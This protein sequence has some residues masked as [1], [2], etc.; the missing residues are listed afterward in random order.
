MLYTCTEEDNKG[1][2]GCQYLCGTDPGVLNLNAIFGAKLSKNL[3]QYFPFEIDSIGAKRYICKDINDVDQIQVL[4]YTNKVPKDFVY[5]EICYK[6]TPVKNYK[7]DL[8]PS[9]NSFNRIIL[10][11]NKFSG[12]ISYITLTDTEYDTFIKNLT[13][14]GQII[15]SDYDINKDYNSYIKLLIGNEIALLDRISINL[16]SN[17]KSLLNSNIDNDYYY[18]ALIQNTVTGSISPS[19]IF[20]DII[21]GAE[22]NFLLDSSK[23]TT[24]AVNTNYVTK[25]DK[26]SKVL[27]P[28]KKSDIFHTVPSSESGLVG[29]GKINVIYNGIDSYVISFTVNQEDYPTD[30]K[31]K[32]ENIFGS[33][34]NYS[35]VAFE[36]PGFFF[37][38]FFKVQISTKIGDIPYSISLTAKT[39]SNKL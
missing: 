31:Q 27:V 21:S 30:T 29:L 16:S 2:E 22:I 4:N 19:T 23:L 8:W 34:G 6:H 11:E 9:Q 17:A 33:N 7:G 1:Q 39:K 37:Y 5:P 36:T 20:N 24:K 28:I 35:G 18:L 12:S 10:K 15:N 13:G 3:L 38:G 32:I 25:Q 26:D 14:S